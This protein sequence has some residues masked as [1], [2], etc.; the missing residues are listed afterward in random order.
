MTAAIAP[1]LCVDVV[2]RFTSLANKLHMKGPVDMRVLEMV[3]PQSGS[4][5]HNLV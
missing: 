5:R 1:T 3:D 2:G 4:D